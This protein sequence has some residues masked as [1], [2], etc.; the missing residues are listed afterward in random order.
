MP[1]V[2]F[3]TMILLF[4]SLY[5]YQQS[6]L[7]QAASAAA[8]R[9]AYSWDNSH[10]EALD[11]SVPVNQYDPLYWRLTDDQWL[12]ALFGWAGAENSQTVLVP[13]TSSAQGA[14]TSIKLS[15]TGSAIPAGM[16]GDMTY[17]N[18]LLQRKVTASLHQMISLRPLDAMLDGGGNELQTSG[19][20]LV[21]D[22]VEFIRS[23]HLMR[24]YGSKFKKHDAG[25]GMDRGSAA[26][27]LQQ[28]QAS[29]SQ[30]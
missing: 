8:E 22:P 30:P 12:G 24:Y 28:L 13:S 14:L 26:G 15:K 4:L 20:S 16:Q 25:E 29:G 5:I 19:S 6:M 23:I 1:V 7:H 27:V 17:Q 10:K 21:V 18:A 11:G 9:T 2:L 3:T